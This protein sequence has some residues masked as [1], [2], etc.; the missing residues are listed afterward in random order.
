M[1]QKRIRGAQF[2]KHKRPTLTLEY[3]SAVISCDSKMNERFPIATWD[4]I[5]VPICSN[6][7][8][9]NINE[10]ETRVF[11]NICIKIKEKSYKSKSIRT[12][13]AAVGSSFHFVK[14]GSCLDSWHGNL[15]SE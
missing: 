13:G 7:G 15:E 11:G 12:T 9:N 14:S 10:H 6:Q 5:T 4:K 8:T 2:A 1:V 3:V